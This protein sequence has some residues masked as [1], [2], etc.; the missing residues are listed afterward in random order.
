MKETTNTLPARTPDEAALDAAAAL[1][2]EQARKLRVVDGEVGRVYAGLDLT[3]DMIQTRI[4]HAGLAMLEAGLLMVQIKE[5][6]GWEVLTGLLDDR[7]LISRRT[8]EKWMAA[9]IKVRR[10]NRSSLEQVGPSKLL[11]LMVLD[12]EDLDELA[13]GGSVA[14]MSLDDIDK[15]TVKELRALTRKQRSEIKEGAEVKERQLLAKDC[16]I[17][18]L[19]D[20]VNRREV[21]PLDERSLETLGLIDSEVSQLAHHLERLSFFS[22]EIRVEDAPAEVRERWQQAIIRARNAVERS[23][24]PLLDRVAI[25]PAGASEFNLDAVMEAE[26]ASA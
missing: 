10:A 5:H 7:F 17:N 2:R 19:E 18:E 23:L 16:R 21:A 1:E 11:E 26:G 22:D 4:N 25:D 12:D 13:E 20:R 14:D 9:A 6:E 24:D 3:V 15:M 8:A